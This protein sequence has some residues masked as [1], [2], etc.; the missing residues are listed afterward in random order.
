M[1]S[2]CPVLLGKSILLIISFFDGGLVFNRVDLLA[3][4][5][6]RPTMA[7]SLLGYT[8]LQQISIANQSAQVA[9][10]VDNHIV[11]RIHRRLSLISESSISWRLKKLVRFCNLHPKVRIREHPA[12]QMKL[13]ISI[14]FEVYLVGSHTWSL[15]P[16]SG[17]LW[18][19]PSACSDPWNFVEKAIALRAPIR[20]VGKYRLWWRSYY[21]A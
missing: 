19:A 15:L 2:S 1:W 14:V 3:A 16:N 7:L 11:L 4:T 18:S 8:G 6:G 17:F 9:I 10:I 12:E 20:S 21:D 13:T 5:S